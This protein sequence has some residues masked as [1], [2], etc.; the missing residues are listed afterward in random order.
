MSNLTLFIIGF[1]IF[2]AYMFFLLRMI[3]KQH[4]IQQK[5]DSNLFRIESEDNNKKA[6]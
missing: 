6:S 1:S 4:N 2:S 3:W 5:S